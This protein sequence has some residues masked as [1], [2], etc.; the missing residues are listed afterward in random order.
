MKQPAVWWLA[1]GV[2]GGVA[3]GSWLP[4]PLAILGA[5]IGLVA[6][7]LAKAAGWPVAIGIVIGLSRILLSPMTPSAHDIAQL[8]GQTVQLEGTVVSY[9][10]TVNGHQQFVA[11][12]WTGTHH[13]R[14]RVAAGSQPH[15]HSGDSIRLTGRLNLPPHFSDFDYRNY[16]AKDGVYSTM[17]RP[18]LT[19][20]ATGGSFTH[21]LGIVREGFTAQ[22]QS[23]FPAQPGGFL[24]GILIGERTGLSN[25]L[26]QAFQRTGTIH[27]LALSGYNISILIAVVIGLTGRRPA[28]LW[29]SFVL[30]GLFVLLVGPA[31]SVVR[32]ALMGSFLL[33]GQ[34][35][36]RPQAAILA[37][38]ITAAA[39]L[40]VSPWA[41][42]YDLGFDLSFLAT[43]GILTLEP[44]IRPRLLWLPAL[45]RETTAATLA[46]SLP[47]L[48][49]IAL[50]FGRVSLIAPLAN[51]LVVPLIPWLM[52]G[53]FAVTILGF[54]G[55]G[56]AVGPAAVVAQVTTLT[57][58]IVTSLAAL[59]VSSVDLGDFKAPAALAL[60]IAALGAVWWLHRSHQVQT[61]T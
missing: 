26:V 51:A 11:I 16:L 18:G 13:G 56:V 1:L 61:A 32:A 53:G 27:V 12:A 19:I 8:A 10:E 34:L 50:S 30:I 44:L 5:V 7:Y 60:A 2:I 58:K 43:L 47:T 22:L 45:L 3:L 28:V 41:L 20:T 23:L 38:M 55:F 49:L 40:G 36:G 33:L 14:V 15:L 31:A 6:L 17:N 59:P 54:V 24:L 52:L 37:C 35:L 25:E 9:P 21:Y 42:R 39:M 4:L 46:A 57:L 29:I 48:P